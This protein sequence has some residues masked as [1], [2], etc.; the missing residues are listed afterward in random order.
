MM[1]VAE[2]IYQLSDL[3][4]QMLVLVYD[5]NEDINFGSPEE[6]A[7]MI[8][9]DGE[10]WLSEQEAYDNADLCKEVPITNE[11]TQVVA[12]RLA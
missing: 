4:P 8:E 9:I 10:L 11:C 2:L 7:S 1:T 12:I 5:P 6:V 3:P